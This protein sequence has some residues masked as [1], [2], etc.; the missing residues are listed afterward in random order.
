MEKMK[1]IAVNVAVGAF[2]CL[3]LI[4]GN[5]LY[6]QHVQ[7]DKGEKGGAAGDFLAAVAGYESAIHMYTPGSPLVERSAK[8]LWE[9]G[10]MAER[11]GDVARAMIAYRSLRSSYYAVAGIYAPGKE[12]IERCDARILFL[13]KMRQGTPTGGSSR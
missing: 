2:I 8:R 9:L 13:L 7:F 6:R 5:T 12:W 1:T 11:R 4:W 10:E 3:T